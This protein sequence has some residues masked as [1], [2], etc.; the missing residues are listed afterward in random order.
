MTAPHVESIAASL[1]RVFLPQAADSVDRS[2]L[3]IRAADRCAPLTDL[4]QRML[5]LHLQTQ[6]MRKPIKCKPL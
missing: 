5:K 6:T 3:G 4:G 1:R 2:W